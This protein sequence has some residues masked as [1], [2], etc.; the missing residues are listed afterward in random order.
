MPDNRKKL[1]RTWVREEKRRHP[2]NECSDL[3]KAICEKVCANTMIMKANRILAFY[4]LADEV[5]ITGIYE[6]LWKQGKK[7]FL[8]RTMGD[9]LK[10]CAFTSEEDMVVG[11]Y[12]IKE[13]KGESLEE[14]TIN[15]IDLALVPG[16][17]FDGNMHRLGRGKGYYDKFLNKYHDIYKI[18]VAYPFQI[19]DEVPSEKHDILMDEVI[20]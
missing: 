4:P 12:G 13:P 19:V 9:D 1:L 7:L 2:Y 3:S 8:P 18:G 11:M 10:I 14:E 17:A 6:T 15:T 5:D 20:S 16:M